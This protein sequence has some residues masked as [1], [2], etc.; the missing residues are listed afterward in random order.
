M[1]ETK[2]LMD[3]PVYLSLSILDLGKTEIYEFWY[4]NVKSKYGEF[5]NMYKQGLALQ[6]M[7]W[8]DNYQ[9]DGT[10]SLLT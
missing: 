7:S 4:D 10:K 3:K 6:I 1:R 9:K 2:I 8:K 5:Q